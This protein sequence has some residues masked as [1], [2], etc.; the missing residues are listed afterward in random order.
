M[1]ISKYIEKLGERL[2]ENENMTRKNV[3]FFAF[4]GQSCR[5][6]GSPSFRKCFKGKKKL[7]GRQERKTTRHMASHRVNKSPSDPITCGVMH[8]GVSPLR[9]RTYSYFFV[10]N[11]HRCALPVPFSFWVLPFFRPFTDC[12]ERY[13]QQLLSSL[14]FDQPL[15]KNKEN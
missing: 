13:P 1:Y 8:V 11:G 9:N 12:R 3:F 5:L 7:R 4:L 6:I 15:K 14:P 10:A 2:S